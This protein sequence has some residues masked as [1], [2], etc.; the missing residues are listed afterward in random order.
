[1]KKIFFSIVFGLLILVLSIGVRLLYPAD[2]R[3]GVVHIQKGMSVD[4]VGRLLEEQSVIRSSDMLKFVLRIT[5]GHG[6]II[7]GEYAF[8]TDQNI[9]SIANR[10]TNGFFLKDQKKAVIPE[11]SNNKEIATIIKENYPSFDVDLF[12]AQTENEQGYLFPDTYYF[13]STST[14]EVIST[15]KKHFEE[16]TKD[17]QKEAQEKEMPWHDVIV[18]A[19]ILEGEANTDI[20]FGIVSG[21]LWKRLEINMPLQ[22]DVEPSTYE[23]LGLPSRPLSNPG[24]ATIKAAL[25]PTSSPYLFYITGKDGKMYYAEDFDKHRANIEAHLK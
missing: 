7:P 4:E 13:S 20:D 19:A 5:G 6:S 24:I 2:F 16:K 10:I 12:L 3:S 14:E 11:G 18:M 8:K 22:V 15:F 21:V 17:L 1:M 23:Q 9:F 25:N